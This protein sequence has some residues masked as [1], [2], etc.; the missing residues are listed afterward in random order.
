MVTHINYIQVLRRLAQNREAARKS[1]LRK[2]VLRQG[3]AYS[4]VIL[5][6]SND[7]HSGFH[8]GTPASTYNTY[9]QAY[10]QQLE[11]SR[12]KLLQLEQELER[13]RQQVRGKM[14]PQYL[15][16]TNI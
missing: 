7:K 4:I 1:R 16:N 13:T 15:I 3:C 11:S 5:K 14:R 8:F 12:L 10:V 2:K 6:K 9:L